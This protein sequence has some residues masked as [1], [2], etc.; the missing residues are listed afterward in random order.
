MDPPPRHVVLTNPEML[1]SGV[2]PHH[3]R[4]ATF[5]GRLRYVVVDELHVFRASSAATSPTCCGGSGGWPT[6][7]APTRRS[8]CCSATIGRPDRLAV[9]AVRLPGRGGRRRRLAAGRAPGR[10]VWNPPPLDE[11]TG[12]R[13]SPNGETAGLVA[14]LVRAGRRRPSPSPGRRATEVVAAD[15]QRR[16]PSRLRRR[17]RPYRGGYLAEERREIEDE[18]FGGRLDGVVATSALELGIDV[19]GLDAVVLNGFPGTIA[20][21]WQ[22]A[23]RAGR[24]GR[25][26]AAV[27]VAGDD[28]LDQWMA[29]HPDELI[30]RPPEP[31]VVNPAN[32]FVADAH[33]RCAAHEMPLTHADE[34]YWPGAARRGGAAA[35]ARRPGGGAAGVAAGAPRRCT[36]GAGGR[37]TAWACGSARAARCAC[38]R[39]RA[40]RSARSS[41]PGRASRRTRGR[42]TCT[43]ASRGGSSTSTSTAARRSS[44]PT[45]GRP[46]RWPAP[47]SP[48]GRRLRRAAPVGRSRWAWAPSRCTSR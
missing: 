39:P 8:C 41:W 10:A 3:D 35:G 45:T 42:R 23:G 19:G 44:S 36:R 18:L 20:S 38:A 33:L 26:S 40:S 17:V 6:T 29:A 30:D 15:V 9:G 4:W 37:R 46:T 1:H 22:Q 16:L 34:R 47:T 11:V 7:T 5:L 2:L 32:P 28:Q 43:P 13:V 12:A 14:E 48:S 25:P 31:V 24:A 27:L 21:F